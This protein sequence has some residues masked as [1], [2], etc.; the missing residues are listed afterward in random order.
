MKYFANKMN[1]NIESIHNESLQ[2]LS[3]YSFPGNIREMR[4]IIE[5]AV[6]LCSG[7][8]LLPTNLLMI[9]NKVIKNNTAELNI[10]DLEVIEKNTILRA[11]KQTNNNKTEAAKLLNIEWNSLHRR[12]LKYGIEI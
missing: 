6:I 1:K 9:N 2:L 12:M 7:N 10:F 11:L 4:N 5:R 3:N 8:E